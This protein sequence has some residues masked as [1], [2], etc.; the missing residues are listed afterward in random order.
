MFGE[1]PLTVALRSGVLVALVLTTASL[2]GAKRSNGP[3][4]VDVFAAIEKGQIAVEFIPRD[5]K[6]CRLLIENKTDKP[7]GVALP[8]AFA[9]VPVL[10]QGFDWPPGGNN[11]QQQQAPQQVG[12][13]IF[14]QNGNQ[15]N[16]NQ[17]NQNMFNVPNQQGN[18]QNP[19][20]I[21][22]IPPE[23]VAKLKFKTVCL[24]HG[25]PEPR[26]KFKYELRP[27]AKVTDKAGVREICSMLGQGKIDQRTAQ[28]AAWHLNN[29]LSW[30][31]LAGMREK[32]AI[33]TTPRYTGE[34][35]K[36]GKKAAKEA[37]EEAKR[38]KPPAASK[39]SKKAPT[40]GG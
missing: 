25:K 30:K 5:S 2:M 1:S 22:N 13:G 39:P 24:E 36:A 33:G 32:A 26:P 37:L 14:G 35:L 38:R 11:G 29:G 18:Q 10:A 7:L 17:G 3:E 23:K 16:Q 8:A 20:Q 15:G 12:G 9:G 28:L 4:V 19:F 31:K 34:E 40:S 6:Q 27:L 21:F